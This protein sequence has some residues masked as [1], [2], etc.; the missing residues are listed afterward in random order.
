MCH[1][2]EHLGLSEQL[3]RKGQ[4]DF[5][6]VI[7]HFCRI[8]NCSVEHFIVHRERARDLWRERSEKTWTLNFGEFGSM[9]P[10]EVIGPHAP[11]VVQ[12]RTRSTKLPKRSKSASNLSQKAKSK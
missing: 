9:V 5:H 3:S 6:A 1:F 4:L 7:N 12:F 8:N 2:V 11:H 10:T